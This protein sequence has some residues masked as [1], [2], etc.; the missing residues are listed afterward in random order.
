MTTDIVPVD[1]GQVP[2][3]YDRMQTAI[4]LCYD[5][6]DCKRIADQANAIAAYYKQIRDDE[7]VRRFLQIKLRA[8][9]RIG[10]IIIN[11]AGVYEEGRETQAAY[12]RRARAEVDTGEMSDWNIIQAAR[13]GQLPDDFFE[14]YAEDHRSIDS[15][16]R[17]YR[18]VKNAEWL[19]TPEGQA[20]KKADDKRQAELKKKFAE[21]D[22]RR[23][24]EQAEKLRKE[25]ED[26]ED[27]EDYIASR[28]E[29]FG[30]VGLTMDRRDR[31]EMK[32]IVFMIKKP[33]HERLRQAAFDKRV[34]MQSVLR[35]GL[36][37]WFVAHDYDTSDL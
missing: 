33:V 14:D 9:R 30:E 13:L 35:A 32:E 21:D 17:T 25:I 3:L 2:Q 37:M 36:K 8:W 29:A 5:V 19:A 27:Y 11:I 26:K 31:K 4:A 22:K 28:D 34:T 20:A 6:D 16:L 10:Q 23:A 24:R 15:L 7:S 18:E 1:S 12:C